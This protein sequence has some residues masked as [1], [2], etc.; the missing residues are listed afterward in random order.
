MPAIEDVAIDVVIVD[1][2]SVDRDGRA[3]QKAEGTRFAVDLRWKGDTAEE[4]GTGAVPVV[5]LDLLWDGRYTSFAFADES[6]Q[7][8][9]NDLIL[10]RITG[11]DK[12]GDPVRYSFVIHKD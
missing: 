5:D 7:W 10:N 1:V 12:N 4:H 3:A 8:E 6:Q 2:W 11:K 9:N